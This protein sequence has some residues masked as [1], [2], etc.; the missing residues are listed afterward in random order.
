MFV[1]LIAEIAN[2]L[3]FLLSKLDK[4]NIFSLTAVFLLVILV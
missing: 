3:G 1:L 2:T 4:S